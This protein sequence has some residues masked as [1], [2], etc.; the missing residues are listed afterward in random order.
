MKY[1]N[2]E[3]PVC[4]R[5]NVFIDKFLQGLKYLI[6]IKELIDISILYNGEGIN[7][8]V[9][10]EGNQKIKEMGFDLYWSR[11]D[12]NFNETKKYDIVGIREDVHKIN[13]NFRPLILQMDDDI[14]I[15]SEKYTLDL[16]AAIVFMMENPT[17][18]VVNIRRYGREVEST[19]KYI[20]PFK[21]GSS[22][23]TCGGILLRNIAEWEGIS[24]PECHKLS[25]PWS[26]TLGGFVRLRAGYAGFFIR[27][28]GYRHYEVRTEEQRP[29]GA[30]AHLWFRESNR[31]NYSVTWL[32]E[33]GLAEKAQYFGKLVEESLKFDITTYYNT[34]LNSLKERLLL[35]E[36]K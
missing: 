14:E 8:K 11:R 35:L 9:V 2:I 27:S 24:P 30:Q 23:F 31:E 29:S 33:Q 34:N 21:E 12:Y 25:G 19:N 15:T 5:T 7:E 18:G 13:P 26:D 6:P 36:N 4:N 1:V 3:V 20:Y 32:K 16:L 28:C 17:A 22:C 10:I